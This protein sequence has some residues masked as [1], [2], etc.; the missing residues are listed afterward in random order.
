MSA[1][2]IHIKLRVGRYTVK[3]TTQTHCGI[4]VTTLIIISDADLRPIRQVLSWSFSRKS[5]R[6]GGLLSSIRIFP[7]R[8]D[9]PADRFAFLKVIRSALAT[10]RIFGGFSSILS[11]RLSH[12]QFYLCSLVP[13]CLR[14]CCLT[15]ENCQHSLASAHRTIYNRKSITTATPP[16]RDRRYQ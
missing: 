16:T 2:V 15:A 8:C 3:N 7:Q 4:E 12:L 5:I 11:L 14:S 13:Q 6:C 10:S 1:R 9:S